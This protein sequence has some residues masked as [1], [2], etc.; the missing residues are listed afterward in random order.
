MN[1][2]FLATVFLCLMSFTVLAQAEKP[3]IGTGRGQ[4]IGSGVG[5]G[6]GTDKGT[7]DKK[8]IILSKPRALFTD[9]ARQNQI[10][11]KVVLRIAFKKNG[12]IG[13]IKVVEG[14]PDGLSENAVK[15]AEGIRF[16]PATKNGKPITVTKNIEYNFNIY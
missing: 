12:K 7:S 10:Q 15:A 9:R 16:E 5:N 4:G 14:L 6:V 11:G 1:N 3:Q 13:K 2:I 8:L